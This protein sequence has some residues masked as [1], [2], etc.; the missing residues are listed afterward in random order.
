LSDNYS[1]EINFRKIDPSYT[2]GLKERG[3]KNVKADFD[4]DAVALVRPGTNIM[5]LFVF[6]TQKQAK[7]E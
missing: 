6:S 3:R 5:I 2:A 1:A 7:F 4:A